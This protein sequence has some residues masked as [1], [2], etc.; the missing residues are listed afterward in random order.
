MSV[1]DVVMISSPGSG[2]SA[3]TAAWTAALPDAQATACSHAEQLGERGLELLGERA[4][5]RRQG[6]AART[7]ARASSSSAP[8]E[9]PL[10]S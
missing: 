7:S 1:I 5:G 3:A 10:A 6:P 8:N 2:S 4:L 9:R